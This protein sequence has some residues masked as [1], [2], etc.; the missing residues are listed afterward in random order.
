MN[1][2]IQR[3]PS[4]NL[5]VC[6]RFHYQNY[7]QYLE[8]SGFLNQYLY[9]DKI[10]RGGEALGIPPAKAVN[11][12][13]K[14]YAVQLHSRILKTRWQV[15]AFSLYHQL[16]QRY[17]LSQWKPADILHVMLHGNTR[18]LMKRAKSERATII[19]EPVN[20]HP[21]ELR[22]LLNEEYERLGLKERLEQN[23]LDERLVAEIQECDHLIVASKW[24]KDSFVKHGFF[25][26][27]TKV[28]PYGINPQRFSP[29]ENTEATLEVIDR[30]KFRVICVGQIALRKGHVDLLEAWRRLKLPNAELLFIG[31][32]KP[33]MEPVLARYKDGFKHIPHV[34]NHLLRHYYGSSHVFALPSVE[35]GFG[36]V[37]VEAM[38]C[39]L[40]VIATINSG[41]SEVIDEGVTGFKVPIR[42]PDA[43]A[44]KIELLYRDRER[45]QAMGQAAREK[46][47]QEMRWDNYTKK[48]CKYYE[49]IIHPV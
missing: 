38:A 43:I 24:I 19:G 18:L 31:R 37:S 26:E 48:L 22:D 46:A 45:Q 32:I 20:C 41:S 29:L 21:D 15:P 28:I 1:D 33:E 42:S 5:A 40:P 35:D 2:Q 11:G 6:G 27:R 14:E 12:F 49:E 4:V 23:A 8:A 44:E 36:Y 30:G 34:P 3:H 7:V 47:V 16:W 10:S 13:F 39:G 17:V 9:A 25:E